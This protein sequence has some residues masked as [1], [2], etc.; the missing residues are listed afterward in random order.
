MAG[1]WPISTTIEFSRH[2]DRD[3]NIKM[4]CSIGLLKLKFIINEQRSIEFQFKSRS[5]STCLRFQN[6]RLTFVA[7][8]FRSSIAETAAS[9]S[10]LSLFET[11]YLLGVF[12]VLFL[13]GKIYNGKWRQY[14]VIHHRLRFERFLIL[15]RCNAKLFNDLRLNKT[16]IITKT[17]KN[18]AFKPGCFW[19]GCWFDGAA[20]AHC[21]FRHDNGAKNWKQSSL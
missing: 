18:A 4:G 7:F 9:L 13:N 14:F 21:L 2:S 10:N 12:P 3:S 5:S 11:S 6:T 19:S 17:F 8:A 1:Y 15:H 16:L 20:F